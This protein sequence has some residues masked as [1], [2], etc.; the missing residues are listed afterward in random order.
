MGGIELTR[1]NKGFEERIAGLDGG[2]RAARGENAERV[3]GP[4]EGALGRG[5]DEG[6]DEEVRGGGGG[7]VGDRLRGGAERVDVEES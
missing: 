2:R 5:G 7:G 6:V 3:D 1:T 4:A